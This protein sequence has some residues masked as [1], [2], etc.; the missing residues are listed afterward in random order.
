MSLPNTSLL[1]L[2]V[3]AGLLTSQI[4]TSSIES[5]PR[6]NYE[7]CTK[8]A[9]CKKIEATVTVDIHWRK[10]P[11][12]EN[13]E[14][15]CLENG[16][17]NPKFCP[18]QDE[19]L[20]NCEVGGID[21][22]EEYAGV[23]NSNQSDNKVNMKFL[24]SEDKK[25]KKKNIGSR[26]YH[27]GQDGQ[28]VLY[29]LKGQ[30]ISFDVD[31]SRLTC[32]MNGAL[33]LS[34]MSSDGGSN[35]Q[36]FMNTKY[37]GSYYGTGYCDAQCPSDSAFN[38]GEI[39]LN[40]PA[41]GAPRKGNCCPEMDIL[42]SN[43]LA[44]A[45]TPHICSRTG[46]STCMGDK[47]PEGPNGFCAGCDFNPHR[48]GSTEFFGP[49]KIVDST[50]PFKIVTQFITDSN[51]DLS[52]IKRIYV[53]NGQIIQNAQAIYPE[54]KAYNS[55]KDDFCSAS[56][57]LFGGKDQFREKG[58]LK[59]LGKSLDDGMVLVLS[60]WDDK[61]ET[62]MLWLDGTFP[63]DADPTKPGVVR[64]P[65]TPAEGNTTLIENKYTDAFVQYGN[66]RIGELDSTYP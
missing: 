2:L 53:Q 6:L 54:L 58:G 8:A 66:I 37:N 23:Y 56:T 62:D 52:E 31:L 29:K 4:Y 39:N 25:T 43:A 5:Q 16:S 47:C 24:V 13:P 59:R 17:W 26:L 18:N 60:L 3:T 65:C 42:E 20:K 49:G 45:F 12:K 38:G 28:Y 63:R 14:I 36:A 19:C 48:L 57:E 50:L 9:G 22:Y 27:L 64:G 44:H 51:H 46:Q 32:G 15:S 11:L 10:F 41:D 35:N 40:P 1:T 55:I 61:S 7:E 34:E 21:N 30:E 33:Y